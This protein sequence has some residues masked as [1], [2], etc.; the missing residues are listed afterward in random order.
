MAWT[1]SGLA[2]SNVP[3]SFVE[4]DLPPF[5]WPTYQQ[6]FSEKKWQMDTV[7]DQVRQYAIEGLERSPQP[8]DS[9][10][11]EGYLSNAPQRHQSVK[12]LRD[13][14][15]LYA[16]A[17]SYEFTHQQKF[18]Q[19]GIEYLSAWTSAYKPTGNDVNENKLDAI[20]LGYT[21]FYPLLERDLRQ[22]IEDWMKTLAEMHISLWDPDEGS[23][24][25]HAK[26]V[27]LILLAGR[28]LDNK[29]LLNFATI[30]YQE[31]LQKCLLPT[32]AT[33]DLERRKSM[34]YNVSCLQ[35]LLEVALLIDPW[36]P[37]IYTLKTENGG[38]L[39][40]SVAFLLPYVLGKQE[41]R[42]WVGTNVEGFDR[43]RAI[44]QDPYYQPG[45]KWDPAEGVFCILFARQYE[46]RLDAPS[47]R[48]LAESAQWEHEAINKLLALNQHSDH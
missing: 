1:P 13:M 45:K 17:W 2:Q 47:S 46:S 3:E 35:V 30:A 32:G 48:L 29:R 36:M 20:F 25:R 19:Q 43:K 33:T 42:E 6:E 26:S 12:Q 10:H 11:Y 41:F 40:R 18:A 4:F 31:L 38:S 44:S 5:V 16:L 15:Y 37:D 14:Q 22:Q 27:K 24:N 7:F 34:H 39:K 23:S 9:I 8:L 28:C 21:I